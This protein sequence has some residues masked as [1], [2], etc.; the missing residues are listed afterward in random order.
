M[1]TQQLPCL[2]Q[3][4]PPVFVTSPVWRKDARTLITLN[5]VDDGECHRPMHSAQGLP[6]KLEMANFGRIVCTSYWNHTHQFALYVLAKQR[7][8]TIVGTRDSGF[9]D[10]QVLNVLFASSPQPNTSRVSTSNTCLPSWLADSNHEQRQQR[11]SQNGQQQLTRLSHYC[12]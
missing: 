1:Q 2:R 8:D 7:K 4:L 11:P 9:Y 5:M 6:D 10:N 3:D 12:C